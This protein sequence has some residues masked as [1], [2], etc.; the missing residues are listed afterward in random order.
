MTSPG[1][2]IA[3]RAAALL[4]DLRQHE[5]AHAD[6]AHA[7]RLS[8]VAALRAWEPPVSLTE[9]ALEVES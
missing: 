8:I 1:Q 3:N 9:L 2:H 6:E 4:A 7:I 5:T